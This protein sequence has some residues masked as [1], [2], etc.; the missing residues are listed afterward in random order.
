METND[1]NLKNNVLIPPLKTREM[2]LNQQIKT[3]KSGDFI[4]K[5]NGIAEYMVKK[6]KMIIVDENFTKYTLENIQKLEMFI[7][8]IQQGYAKVKRKL[9]KLEKKRKIYL[10]SL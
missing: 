3:R 9:K 5:V 8:E 4:E 6:N 10:N 1:T 7:L 2:V